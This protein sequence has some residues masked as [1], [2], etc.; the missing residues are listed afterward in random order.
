M[1][2]TT[3]PL[4]CQMALNGVQ[5]EDEHA[6]ELTPLEDLLGAPTHEIRRPFLLRSV[7]DLLHS[8]AV[9]S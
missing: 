2:I 6:S 3:P 7:S 8:A 4:A 5:I 9:T 1:P